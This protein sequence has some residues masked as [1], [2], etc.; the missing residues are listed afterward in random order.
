VVDVVVLL[1]VVLLV[2][3][4]IGA[5]VEVV[6]AEPVVVAALLPAADDPSGDDA[7]LALAHADIA[8]HAPTSR[9]RARV[10]SVAAS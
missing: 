4:G 6:D 9:C 2:V 1:V 5:L 3:L 10:T 8:R 7:E